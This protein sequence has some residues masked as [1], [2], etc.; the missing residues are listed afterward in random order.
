[1]GS[2][3]LSCHADKRHHQTAAVHPHAEQAAHDQAD[4]LG[5]RVG[6]LVS[7]LHAASVDLHFILFHI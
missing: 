2:T 6:S 7:G 5:P 4:H 3:Q 1:M